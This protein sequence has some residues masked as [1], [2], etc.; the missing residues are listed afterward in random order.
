M[1]RYNSSHQFHLK[2]FSSL[3]KVCFFYWHLYRWINS[4][5][6]VCVC[7]CCVC[8]WNVDM[9]LGSSAHFIWLKCG[10]SETFANFIFNSDCKFDKNFG[11]FLPLTWFHI[12]YNQ[13]I[14][15]TANGNISWT[16]SKIQPFTFLAKWS[17]NIT[18]SNYLNLFMEAVANDISNEQL[19]KT[20]I[21]PFNCDICRI[22]PKQKS[23]Q[24]QQQQHQK[25]VSFE[26]NAFVSS[27]HSGS[28]FFALL[29]VQ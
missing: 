8:M 21:K 28:L 23:Q 7:C 5:C 14:H 16:Q 3:G 2:T 13:S 22:L 29:C 17:A 24:Q 6:T 27:T 15:H 18:G 4:M 20:E 19:I 26:Q 12:V 25:R 11:L 1:I 9:N 10:R